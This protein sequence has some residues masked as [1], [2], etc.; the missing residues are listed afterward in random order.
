MQR[1]LMVVEESCGLMDRVGTGV[2]QRDERG[3]ERQLAGLI[4]RR[5]M[6]LFSGGMEKAI[7]GD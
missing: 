1:Y 3:G 7:G 2:V 5:K 4:N 6:A